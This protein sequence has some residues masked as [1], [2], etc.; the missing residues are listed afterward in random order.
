MDDLYGNVYQTTQYGDKFIFD[1][2]VVDESDLQLQ[3]WCVRPITINSIVY[4]KIREG[5]E[6]WWRIKDIEPKTGGFLAVAIISDTNPD[7]S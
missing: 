5:G 6:R 4:R 7:F 3:F 1:A 2:V